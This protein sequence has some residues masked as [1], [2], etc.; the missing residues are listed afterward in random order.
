MPRELRQPAGRLMVLLQRP[1]GLRHRAA[2]GLPALKTSKGV[3][4]H[5]RHKLSL[6]CEAH[7]PNSRNTEE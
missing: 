3:I 2:T 7:T 6:G 1:R 4:L 5:S